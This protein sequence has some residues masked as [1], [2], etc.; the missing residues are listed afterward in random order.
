MLATILYVVLIGIP[1]ALVTLGAVNWWLD[2]LPHMC[3]YCDEP[4]TE[5]FGN[6]CAHCSRDQE[7][8]RLANGDK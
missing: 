8:L 3:I 2:R 4:V 7:A 5:N 1:L 6:V